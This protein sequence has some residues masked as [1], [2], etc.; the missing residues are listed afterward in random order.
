[1][2]VV[3]LV[4]IAGCKSGSDAPTEGGEDD[5]KGGAK[6]SGGSK[7]SGGKGGAQTGGTTGG[8]EGGA[9]S[10][11]GGAGMGGDNG[12]GGAAMGG[13]TGEGGAGDGG[14]GAG[15][16]VTGTGGAPAGDCPAGATCFD[17]EKDAAGA[18][19]GAPW[20]VGATGKI[21][22]ET[23]KAVSGKQAVHITA[24]TSRTEGAFLT[25]A[26][27]FP[28]ASNE[29]FGRAM[30]WAETIPGGSAH[31][32]FV[33]SD[34]MVPGKTFKAFYTYGAEGSKIIAN[35]DSD[36]A[37]SDCWKFGGTVQTKK[38]VCIEWHFKG[39]ATGGELELWVDGTADTAHV[40]NKGDGCLSNAGTGGVWLAPTFANARI[41]YEGYAGNG[42]IDL[43]YDDIAIGDARVG[44]P[45]KK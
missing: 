16:A 29:Y 37:K 11:A 18:G 5:G 45:A 14:S 15:G 7:G 3:A 19:P 12:G 36:P 40:V 21:T 31:W 4:T 39:T 22:V 20:M 28:K 6:A 33:Q 9:G 13:K 35:Y 34:G 41:G 8:G 17:F 27:G 1:V 43:W 25:L 30:M 38:W 10:G 2:S 32:T 44:C 24:P 42:P 23:G 26:E